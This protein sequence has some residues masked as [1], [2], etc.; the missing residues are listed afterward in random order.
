MISVRQ[1]TTLT[2]IIAGFLLLATT[3]LL[4]LWGDPPQL[5]TVPPVDPRFT[6]PTTVRQ[7]LSD[8]IRAGE[9]TVFFECY[10]CHDEDVTPELEFDEDLRI[11]LPEEHENI[12]MHHGS[13]NRNNHCFNCHNEDNLETLQTR[14]HQTLPLSESSR[15]CASCHGPTY[16]DWEAGIHGR[17]SGYWD[18][19]QGPVQKQDCASCH[20]PHNPTFPPFEPAPPPR[21]LP[22]GPD[23]GPPPATHH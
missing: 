5:E 13:H 6:E 17:S 15:L 20:N 19:S 16:R 10:L 8:L 3:F 1:E 14:D 4:D 7:S 22:Y 12:E 21:G 9:D 2:A 23:G 11:V 18:R